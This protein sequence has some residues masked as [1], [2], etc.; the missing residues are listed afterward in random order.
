MF[1]LREKLSSY[2]KAIRYYQIM[3]QKQI[4][5]YRLR[6]KFANYM[7]EE[8]LNTALSD[9]LELM[10]SRILSQSTY[11]GIKALKSPVDFW[12]YQEIIFAQK[13]EIIVEIGTYCGGGTLALAHL[14][15]NLGHGRIISIDIN[16]DLASETV[17]RHPRVTLITGD[18]CQVYASVKH[19]IGQYK[20]VLVIE[21]SAHSY[22]ATLSILRTYS[23]LIPKGG[24]FIVED[25]IAHHGLNSGPKPGP[26]EAVVQFLVENSHFVSDRNRESFPITWNPKGY[27]LR[28]S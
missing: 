27:L 20:N 17:R 23:E 14:L 6:K 1:K 7:M 25:S 19:S 15:D 5:K 21:D 28:V 11:F 16:H 9:I 13:P 18:A 2:L 26:Y 4:S 10:Q 24:Y 22:D 8:R 3:L 12:V